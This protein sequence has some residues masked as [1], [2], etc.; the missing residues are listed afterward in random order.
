MKPRATFKETLFYLLD[1]PESLKAFEQESNKIK[2]ALQEDRSGNERMDC[3]ALNYSGR[4]EIK[5]K[6]DIAKEGLKCFSD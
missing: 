1:T 2:M 4:N 6:R 5:Q 3:N